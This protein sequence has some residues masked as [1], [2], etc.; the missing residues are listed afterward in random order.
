MNCLNRIAGLVLCATVLGCAQKE[1]GVEP[2]G[3]MSAGKGVVSVIMKHADNV[4]RSFAEYVPASEDELVEHRVEILVFDKD[5]GKLERSQT[6]DAISKGCTLDVLEGLKIVYAVVNGPDLS[7]V[8]YLSDLLAL[9]DD[10]NFRSMKNDGLVMMGYAECIV[11][12]GEEARILIGL[13]WL[14][15]RVVLTRLTNN[16]ARQYE[17]MKVECIYLGDANV[18]QTLSGEVSGKVNPGGYERE[19]KSGPIGLE[20]VTGACPDYIFRA[21]GESVPVGESTK[22]EY[23]L[24]CHPNTT[25]EHTSLYILV[26][27]DGEK[28]YYRVPLHE[29]LVANH[30]YSVEAVIS[31]F[32]AACPPDGEMQKGQIVATIEMKGWQRGGSYTEKF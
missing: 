22:A 4:N 9:A 31:N 13:K 24:Y 1:Q 17:S 11:A 30:T 3:L 27:I 6:L 5:S 8:K 7:Q 32:G 21:V 10:M 14:A 28:Y 2:G 29:G 26:S 19:E 20:N 25:A 18:R 15:S 12:A 16:I 23:H